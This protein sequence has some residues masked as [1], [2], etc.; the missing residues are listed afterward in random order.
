MSFQDVSCY[1]MANCELCRYAILTQF[2]ALNDL[3]TV[4]LVCS[5]SQS[6]LVPSLDIKYLNLES[7]LA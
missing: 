5:S 1:V 6:V 7:L 3:K 2:L 4:S